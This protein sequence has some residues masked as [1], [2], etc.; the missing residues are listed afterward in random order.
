MNTVRI[1]FA[2]TLVAGTV[3]LP[4]SGASAATPDQGP[5]FGQHVSQC[6]K[7]MG[8][9][10]LHNPGMHQGKSGWDHMMSASR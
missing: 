2:A 6:A 8:F 3:L 1:V 5:A 4:S 9:S 7:T 10:G